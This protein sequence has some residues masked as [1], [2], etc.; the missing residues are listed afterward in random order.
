MQQLFSYL[1]RILHS[2]NGQEFVK[3][4]I[5]ATLDSWHADIQLISGCPRHPQSKAWLNELIIPFKENEISRMKSKSS[6]WVSWIQ[7]SDL[8]DQREIRSWSEWGL[9][10]A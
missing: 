8:E 6:P 7:M 2:Y 10:M 9:D 5:K 1:P 3:S 4:I